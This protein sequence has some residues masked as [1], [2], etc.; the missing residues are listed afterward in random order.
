MSCRTLNRQCL[1][2]LMTAKVDVRRYIQQF[3]AKLCLLFSSSQ[4][5]CRSL[6][7]LINVRDTTT[8]NRNKGLLL[9]VTKVCDLIDQDMQLRIQWNFELWYVCFKQIVFSS[10]LFNKEFI[11]WNLLP[12]T[13]LIDYLWIQISNCGIF[14]I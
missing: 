4:K 13:D 6:L 1:R 14:G 12:T 7:Y 3:A 10:V 5:V 8:Y 9:C 2:Y 11:A